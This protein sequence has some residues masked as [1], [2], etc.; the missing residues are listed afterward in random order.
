MSLK[1]LGELKDLLLGFDHEPNPILRSLMKKESNVLQDISTTVI[2]PPEKLAKI[3]PAEEIVLSLEDV[4]SI[5]EKSGEDLTQD[6]IENQI[7]PAILEHKNGIKFCALMLSEN[8]LDRENTLLHQ[9]IL[10]W[11]KKYDSNDLP[12]EVIEIISPPGQKVI[13]QSLLQHSRKPDWTVITDL[14]KLDLQDPEV[15]K[16]LAR[17]ILEQGP[18][19]DL[20]LGKQMLA[21]I[22]SLPRNLDAQI[23]ENWS[24]A[25]SIHQSFLSKMCMNELNKISSID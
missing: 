24:Q 20:G 11:M 23:R 8:D 18:N 22:K 1:R 14:K 4:E 13:L 5:L 12:K 15:Q 21:L 17:I 6:V 16:C 10:P 2:E 3:V 25:V 19:K 7:C 9:L